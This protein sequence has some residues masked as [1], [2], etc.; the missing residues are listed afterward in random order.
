MV[1]TATSEYWIRLIVMLN[2]VSVMNKCKKVPTLSLL[3][4]QDQ[5]PVTSVGLQAW[6]IIISGAEM[7]PTLSWEG[8]QFKL[9]TVF[10]GFW[11]DGRWRMAE[12]GYNWTGSDAKFYWPA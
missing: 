12:F 6:E 1:E 5:L 4:I 11:I 7:R 3:L 8:G 10:G 2:Y 9:T